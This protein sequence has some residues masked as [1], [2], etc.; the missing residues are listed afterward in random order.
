M[1]C[2]RGWQ[3]KAFQM[4]NAPEASK[5]DMLQQARP[6]ISWLAAGHK[7]VLWLCGRHA[8]GACCQPC[9]ELEGQGLRSVPCDSPHSQ[10]QDCSPGCNCHKP[11]RQHSRLFQSAGASQP[12][13]GPCAFRS[14]KVAF[15]MLHRWFFSYA[16]K[17]SDDTSDCESLPVDHLVQLTSVGQA[18]SASAIGPDQ[19]IRYCINVSSLVLY[20]F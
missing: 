20:Q 19:H 14:F 3:R 17:Q 6:E 9:S 7:P 5:T 4:N 1:S 15:F 13:L 2:S 11:A 8:G 12:C 18:C 16:M 10:R